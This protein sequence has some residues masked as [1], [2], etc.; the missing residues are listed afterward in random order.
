[1]KIKFEYSNIKTGDKIKYKTGIYIALSINGV[2]SYMQLDTGCACT[3]LMKE[4]VEKY[5][6]VVNFQSPRLDLDW[7]GTGKGHYTD[8]KIDIDSYA[9]N[10]PFCFI[11]SDL[12]DH[13][14]KE[15]KEEVILSMSLPFAGY[16]GL[17]FFA[18]QSFSIDFKNEIIE[19]CD[20][21]IQVDST[22]NNIF[23]IDHGTICIP[24]TINDAKLIALFDTATGHTQIRLENSLFEKIFDQKY[25]S[26]DFEKLLR[27]D[28]TFITFRHEVIATIEICDK[29][30]QQEYIIETSDEHFNTFTFDHDHIM[31]SAIICK[32]F[33]QNYKIIFD[34]NNKTFKIE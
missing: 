32:Q 23:Y 12:T 2:L 21:S 5:P 16:L 11:E 30:I 18:K 25:L 7:Y 8:V 26:K 20:H 22:I 33:F 19:L 29:T 1:M 15:K 34:M 27:P 13:E 17:D 6:E 28:F 31:Y 14:R 9:V 10:I 4:F 3:F 24:V